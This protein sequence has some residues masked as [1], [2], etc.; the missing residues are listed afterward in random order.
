MGTIGLGSWVLENVGSHAFPVVNFG[1]YGT[2]ALG[3]G[4]LPQMGGVGGSGLWS[5]RKQHHE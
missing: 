3:N 4:L 5:Q 1:G 2:Y